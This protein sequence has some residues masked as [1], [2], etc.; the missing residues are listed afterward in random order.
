M[1][2][3]VRG[4]ALAGCFPVRCS[5]YPLNHSVPHAFSL[6]ERL[7]FTHLWTPLPFKPPTASSPATLQKHLTWLVIFCF[8][9]CSSSWASELVH[10]PPPLWT[11]LL[12]LLHGILF[13]IFFS[14]LALVL[15]FLGFHAQLPSPSSWVMS[16]ASSVADPLMNSNLD[17]L[18][19]QM[20][21]SIGLVDT[22][23]W[24]SH[25]LLQPHMDLFPSLLFLQ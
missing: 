15:W 19:F 23:T 13:P 8:L 1:P 14:H 12:S 20:H 7:V 16:L 9:E 10:S 17:L 22:S 24:L 4:S 6:P 25:K 2:G 5:P 18:E 3:P 11:L 21:S